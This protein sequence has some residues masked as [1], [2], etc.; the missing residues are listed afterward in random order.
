[1]KVLPSDA[2]RVSDPVLL[3]A[4]I[5]AAGFTFVEQCHVGRL[6]ALLEV[7]QLAGIVSLQAKMVDAWRCA[8]RRHGEIDAGIVQH[9]FRIVRFDACRL[10]ANSLE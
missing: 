1:M 4:G 2:L 3:A 7:R 10:G 6:R 5:A 9:P 8:A